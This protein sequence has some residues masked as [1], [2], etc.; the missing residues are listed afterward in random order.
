[1]NTAVVEGLAPV[2]TLALVALA[3]DAP[4][5]VAVPP[6][7]PTHPFAYARDMQERDAAAIGWSLLG[8]QRVLLHASNPENPG[9]WPRAAWESAR[10]ALW[11]IA[12]EFAGYVHGVRDAIAAAYGRASQGAADGLVDCLLGAAALFEVDMGRLVGRVTPGAVNIREAHEQALRAAY[13]TPSVGAAYV[14]EF[15]RARERG[16]IPTAPAVTVA[17]PTVRDYA[18]PPP[19][20]V[21]TLYALAVGDAQLIAWPQRTHEQIAQDERALGL[22]WLA[23]QRTGWLTQTGS[24]LVYIAQRM[25]HEALPE[26][27]QLARVYQ[28]SGLLRNPLA[29]GDTEA[30]GLLHLC[31]VA[32]HEL[33]ALRGAQ[34]VPVSAVAEELRAVLLQASA[35]QQRTLARAYLHEHAAASSGNYTQDASRATCIELPFVWAHEPTA[36]VVCV[37]ALRAIPSRGSAAMYTTLHAANLARLRSVSQ[38][39]AAATTIKDLI[40]AQRI[41]P[42]TCQAVAEYLVQVQTNIPAVDVLLRKD[43][44]ANA[45][46][47]RA[48]AAQL[49]ARWHGC[50]AHVGPA[51]VLSAETMFY[52]LL[53]PAAA[54][55]RLQPVGATAPP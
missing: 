11:R 9:A 5:L 39:S 12:P 55:R 46:L 36:L 35:A 13:N 38:W 40:D 26:F 8:T 29:F 2:T 34:P 3:A 20:A 4:A 27:T 49:Q 32:R 17:V 54:P 25:I 31:A 33:A 51:D 19:V 41:G 50:W 45:E 30:Q 53:S 28:Q 44:R 18:P 52:H 1:M 14:A 7:A 24:P 42:A 23:V 6:A 37:D 10:D 22:A 47:V 16:Y 48:A 43:T 15:A 21:S